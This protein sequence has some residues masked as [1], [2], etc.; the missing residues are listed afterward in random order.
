M[1]SMNVWTHKKKHI[2]ACDLEYRQIRGDINGCNVKH[3][4]NKSSITLI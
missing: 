1:N 4:L 2:L 3:M